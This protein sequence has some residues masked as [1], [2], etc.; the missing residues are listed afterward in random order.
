M[1]QHTLKQAW[2][3]VVSDYECHYRHKQEARAR[4]RALFLPRVLANPS[5]HATILWRVSNATPQWCWPLW[6]NILITKHSMDVA[7]TE[8]GPGLL[9]PHPWGIVVGRGAR[10]GRD[11]CIYHNV[12]LGGRPGYQ[13]PD[14]GFEPDCPVIGDDVV[15]YCGAMLVGRVNVGDGAV[16]GA[17]AWIDRDVPAGALVP[18][19]TR[20]AKGQSYDQATA[21]KPAG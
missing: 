16:I 3:L 6:R 17:Y 12:T 7:P 18:G 19:G 14:G 5:L 1:R 2:A 10:L 9:L 21:P 13:R 8:I 11:C 4:R 15:I 20:T